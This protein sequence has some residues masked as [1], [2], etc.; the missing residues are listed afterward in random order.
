MLACG[1]QGGVGALKAMGALRMGLAESELQPLVDAWRD[2]NPNI[3]QLWTDVNAAAIEAISTSQPVKIGPLTFAVEHWLFTHLPSGR[4]LAYARPRLS[5][6]RFGGTAII[7]DGIT[8]GRKRGKLKT[9]GGKLIE[10]IVQAIA[11]DPLTHA[12]H[13]VEATGHE[14]VMHIHDK[15][16]IENRRYDRWRHLPP[17]PTTPAWSK[18]LPL[19]ADGY[20]C[21]FY[22]KD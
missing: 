6:N 15:I 14:I 21:A 10:N 7:Y 11:P 9:C 8:K 4:Q 1:Y 22:R 2:A 12:M 19:A 13:H 16:V 5:E 20:E 18:G 17:L 3:V